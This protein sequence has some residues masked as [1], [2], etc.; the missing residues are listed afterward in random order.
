MYKF[1]EDTHIKV[2]FFIK[3]EIQGKDGTIYLDF[4]GI[5]PKFSQPPGKVTFYN[6]DNGSQQRTK[7]IKMLH[8]ERWNAYPFDTRTE[9]STRPHF[10]ENMYAANRGPPH[11]PWKPNTEEDFA[12]E[13]FRAQQAKI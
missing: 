11:V 13:Q 4:C 1:F 7:Q 5:G 2:S 3:D 9:K 12:L 6:P 8:S 10:G